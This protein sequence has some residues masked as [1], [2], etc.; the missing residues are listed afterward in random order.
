[1]QKLIG[2][3]V[4]K[5]NDAPPAKLISNYLG[6]LRHFYADLQSKKGES[7]KALSP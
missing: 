4:T 7:S 3:D 1:M 2:D 5:Y 6:E